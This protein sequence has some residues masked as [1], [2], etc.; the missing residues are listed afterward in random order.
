M[1]FGYDGPTVDD[2]HQYVLEHTP[3]ALHVDPRMPESELCDRSGTV[4]GFRWSDEDQYVS[5]TFEDAPEIPAGYR[6][7]RKETARAPV[8]SATMYTIE[9]GPEERVALLPT[10]APGSRISG[11]DGGIEER[12][13]WSPPRGLKNG[14]FGVPPEKGTEGRREFALTITVDRSLYGTAGEHPEG[15]DMEGPPTA[16]EIVGGEVETSFSGIDPVEGRFWRL[17]PSRYHSMR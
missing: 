16:Q 8:T 9:E 5:V 14:E 6:R 13:N 11:V 15:G 12:P 2:L 1:E 4:S 7:G 3:D 10:P 17:T